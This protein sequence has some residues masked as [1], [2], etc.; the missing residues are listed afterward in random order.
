MGVV[1]Y[2][3]PGANLLENAVGLGLKLLKQRN[4]IVFSGLAIQLRAALNILA[5]FLAKIDLCAMQISKI[6]LYVQS[7]CMFLANLY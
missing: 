1:R 2:Q 7:E 3:S 4:F 6:A 5:I